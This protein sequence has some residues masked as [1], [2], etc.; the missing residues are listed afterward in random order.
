MQRDVNKTFKVLIEANSKKSDNDWHGRT[1]HNKVVIFPKE[2]YQL[3]K[4]DYVEVFVH[5]CT[6]GTLLGK[7]VNK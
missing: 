7:I 6:A 1:D 2:H 5:T 3:Q 4:G